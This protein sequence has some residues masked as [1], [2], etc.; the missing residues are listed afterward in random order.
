M[1]SVPLD[2][3]DPD[4]APDRRVAHHSLSI[5]HVIHQLPVDRGVESHL[6]EIQFHF[7][8][9]SI[10]AEV[11]GTSVSHGPQSRWVEIHLN[12]DLD[13]GYQQFAEMK[14]FD[15]WHKAK[16]PFLASKPGKF[17]MECSYDVLVFVGQGSEIVVGFIQLIGR[18]GVW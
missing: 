17:C 9:C 11:D 3:I 18:Q 6:A 8:V 2:V 7:D 12:P 13:I 14:D 15:V 4:L 1:P 16:D 10:Q 5:R